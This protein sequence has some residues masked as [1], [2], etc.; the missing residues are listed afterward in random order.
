[1]VDTRW[2]LVGLC[3]LAAG[4]ADQAQTAKQFEDATL[5]SGLPGQVGMTYGS[6]WGDYDND[7]R[8]DVYVTNHL[9]DAQLF[10][11]L[12]NRRFVDVTAEAFSPEDLEGDKHGATWADFDND[13]DLD[14]VQ[15]GGAGR[16][17]GAEPKRLFRNTGSR[18]Q[19][20]A[21]EMGVS[22]PQSRTRMPLWVDADSDGRL[23]LFHGA[24]GRFDQVQPPYFFL[25]T[26]SGFEPADDTLPFDARS[27][28]FCIVTQLNAHPAPEVVCRAVGSQLTAR[29]FDTASVPATELDLL[30]VSAFEDL[31]AGDFDNDGKIDLFMARNS[32]PGPVALERPGSNTLIAD[33]VV[34]PG[35][36]GSPRGFRF[37]T[38]GELE[39]AV[40][41]AWPKHLLK[42]RHVS[43]GE[44]GWSPDALIFGLSP[45]TAGVDGL[46]TSR[47]ETA[48]VVHIG[49][50]GVDTW[51]VQ[52]VPPD[53]SKTR[54]HQVAFKVVSSEP[55]T[56][57]EP[58]GA[59]LADETA[60]ARL[61]MNRDGKLVEESGARG[62]NA[63]VVAGVNAVAGDFD[64]DMDLDLYVLASGLVGNHPN[65]LLLN[66]GDGHF[67]AEPAA[68]G[69]AGTLSG[70]GDN[71]TTVDYDGDGFLDLF[72]TNGGS[73][74]RSLGIPSEAGGYALYRNKGNG[75]HWIMIDLEGTGSNRDGIGA[76][77]DV[78]ADD[79]TQV[80][81][82]DG[83]VHHRGQNH[84]RL[85]F[86]LG[87]HERVDTIR[88]QWPNGT[89]QELR[90][91]DAN[92]VLDIKEPA[93]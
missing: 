52:L 82:Q 11:N 60:P 16:G 83:G 45:E 86:G 28:P 58:V 27:V 53:G 48:P 20:T 79:L 68:G 85:H 23:D 92:Q 49:R 15:L 41:P 62:V 18:L 8:P 25:W 88:V 75:N 71:V 66:R 21:K 46:G 12:G 81:V 38:E 34:G 6:Y 33:V 4:C 26:N 84:S 29:I 51:Q 56:D 65:Q 50:V 93:A 89:V 7:G 57:R 80:R 35:G 90:D 72:V 19:D 63:E 40:A 39:V 76:R 14:L 44:S 24:E 55:I 77:V 47:P 54:Q 9:N 59:E 5:V 64:N 22:N 61:F 43:I 32:F 87:P 70:V 10:R 31:A 67:E 30:P 69:A 17:V 74:G 1:M 13:G 37:R 78:T 91:V 36:D 42:P 3:S 73:M 2:L